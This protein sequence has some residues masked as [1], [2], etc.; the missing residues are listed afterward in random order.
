VNG[1][2]LIVVPDAEDEDAFLVFADGTI[3]GWP[4]RFLLDT[5]AA[6]TCVRF[7]DHTGSFSPVGTSAS[8]GLFATG[9]RTDVIVVPR[10]E[11]GPI[12]RTEV[13]VA[14]GPSTGPHAGNL[15]GMDVL[16]DHRCH[17]RFAEMRVL[18][19]P[20]DDPPPPSI[21]PL[22]LD[23]TN[24]PN[25]DVRFGADVAHAAWDTGAGITIVDLGLVHRHP[26]A[27]RQAG[28]SRGT[29]STGATMPSPIFV[30][31]TAVIGGLPF[32]PH[33]VAGVDLS[34]VNARIETPMDV[35]LGYI[36]LSRADWW[37]DFPGH[38]WAVTKLTAP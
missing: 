1:F 17:F 20:P 23:P 2:D 31:A 24:H 37:F 22:H 3:D 19:D 32:P 35:E 18:V 6:R 29:D 27:F 34:P 7:D 25:V 21:Q 14:R 13:P 8:S 28:E 16:K 12:A 30:M 5:G 9:P 10:L 38:R 33:T 26:D 36:T 15:I 4:Y 11:L